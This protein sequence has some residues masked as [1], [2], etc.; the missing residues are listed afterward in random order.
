MLRGMAIFRGS[1]TTHA[2]PT[3]L[4]RSGK[5]TGNINW[6]SSLIKTLNR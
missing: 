1:L 3:Q 6:L 4:F 2:N 5:S